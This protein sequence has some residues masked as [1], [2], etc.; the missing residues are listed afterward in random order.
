MRL[1]RENYLV[2]ALSEP[3]QLGHSVLPG[4]VFVYLAFFLFS[5]NDWPSNAAIDRRAHDA[6]AIDLQLFSSGFAVAPSKCL[7]NA[8]MTNR[9]FVISD[10]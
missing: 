2:W 8:H 4:V 9:G 6:R 7:C 1:P 10:P 5:E 3:F